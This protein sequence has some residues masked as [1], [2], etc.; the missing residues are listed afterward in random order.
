MI[1]RKF[2]NKQNEHRNSISAQQ[3]LAEQDNPSTTSEHYL[4][5]ELVCKIQV[6]II[7]F[8]S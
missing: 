8:R 7:I 6:I 4:I 2:I 5:V 3:R 1:D